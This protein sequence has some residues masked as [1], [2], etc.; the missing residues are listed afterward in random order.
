M[1]NVVDL[2]KYRYKKTLESDIAELKKVLIS[3]R[4]AY[5]VL[6]PHLKYPLI[7]GIGNDIL[8][9]RHSIVGNIEALQKTQRELEY[10]KVH[11][12]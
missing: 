2:G 5:D 9:S 3:L 8:K 11:N 4:E 10:E 7:S 1:N 6:I 12:K